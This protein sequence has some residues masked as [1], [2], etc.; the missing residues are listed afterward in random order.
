MVLP[1]ETDNEGARELAERLRWE[2]EAHAFPEVGGMTPSF[3]VA[4]YV[5]GEGPGGW[6]AGGMPPS[7][8][9]SGRDA[10]RWSPSPK[11]PPRDR[12][13]VQVASTSIRRRLEPSLLGRVTRK[14]PLR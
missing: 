12:T 9:P 5:G 3:G 11:S 8:G 13:S 1:H 4:E 7:T 14:T 10:P 2:L 6:L